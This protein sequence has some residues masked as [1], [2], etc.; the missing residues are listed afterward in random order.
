MNRNKGAKKRRQTIPLWTYPE[1][2]KALPYLTSVMQTVRE[3]RIEAKRH[4]R[5][6]RRLANQPGR[7]D[8]ATLIAHQDESHDAR[9]ANDRFHDALNELHDLGVY[10][11]D[12][13]RGEALIPF[14]H[15]QQLAWFVYDLFEP[16]GLRFWR[17]HNDP[18]EKRRLIQE[19][20]GSAR[21]ETAVA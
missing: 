13:V 1:A 19:I 5:A 8:R 4:H 9:L 3:Y 17:Y 11:L 20:E 12:A 7:P 15:E 2:L 21:G 6:A 14:A 10:C 16:N 18:L